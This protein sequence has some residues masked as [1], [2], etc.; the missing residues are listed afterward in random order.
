VGPDLTRIGAQRS[1]RELLESIS[2]PSAAFAPGYEPFRIRVRDGE[3]YDGFL[4][5]ESPTEV[6]LVQGDRTERRIPK[7]KVDLIE[8]GA[9][10]VMPQGFGERLRPGELRDL[11][12]FLGTLR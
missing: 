6:V 7:D 11:L 2:F 12:A 8:R 9:V 1:R 10:S 3:V 5:R 4:S